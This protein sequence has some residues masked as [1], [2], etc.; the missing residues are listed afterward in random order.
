LLLPRTPYEADLISEAA[1][2]AFLTGEADPWITEWWPDFY[3]SGLN[4]SA[5]HE[6]EHE[7]RRHQD[8]VLR[9]PAQFK[10]EVLK[11]LLEAVTSGNN[12]VAIRGLLPWFAEVEHT[13]K[14]NWF[15]FLRV[16]ARSHGAEL[17][18][19]EVEDMD[20]KIRREVHLTREDLE[21]REPTLGDHLNKYVQAI[22]TYD[23]AWSETLGHIRPAELTD[24]RNKFA[25]GGILT[26]LPT[27]WRSVLELIMWFWPIYDMIVR[28]VQSGALPNSA[29]E[30]Q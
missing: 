26:E 12:F 7:L 19:K 16:L 11:P 20:L 8:V 9:L 10:Q 4:T 5:V 23:E 17:S 28:T 1:I 6:V 29:G 2:Q 15:E 30:A 27:A 21:G 14:M 18:G 22:K 13:L 24:A 25:H 3:S